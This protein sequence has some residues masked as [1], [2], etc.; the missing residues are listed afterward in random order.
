M[1]SPSEMTNPSF[2]I[3]EIDEKIIS[4]GEYINQNEA[5]KK[6]SV[7]KFFKNLSKEEIE[8]KDKENSSYPKYFCDINTKSFKYIGILTNELK[9]DNYGY[10]LMDNEDEFLGEYSNELREGYGI[11]KYRYKPSEEKEEI[12]F[13]EY[14]NNKKEGKGIYIKIN[15]SIKDELNNGNYVLINF[16]TNIGVFKDDII[17]E[18]IILSVKDDKERLYYGKLNDLGEQED[19]EGLFIEDKNKIFKGKISKGN[20][21]EGRNIFINDKYEKIKGYYFNVIK[22]ENNE[23]QYEFDNNKN[24]EKDEEIIIKVKELLEKNYKKKIQEIYDL[25]NEKFNLFKNYEKALNVDFENDIK[26]EIKDK[27]DNAIMN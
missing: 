21:S 26:N 4:T 3:N 9:R 7:F 11:Y 23:E 13:G 25:I 18:G 1:E 8:Q 16:D 15:K 12:Y 17:K 22:K 24:E 14:H 19:N 10:S 5:T 2:D 20:L 6:K 27:L